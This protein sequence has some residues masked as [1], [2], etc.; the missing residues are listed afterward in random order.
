M[1]S[2][3]TRRSLALLLLLLA[4]STVIDGLDASIVN[5]A[6]PTISSDLHV[7]VADTSSITVSYILVLA[8]LLL[9]FAKLAGNGLVKRMFIVGTVVFTV[10]SAMCGLSM[11]FDELVV[12]RFIQG[13]GAGLMTAAVP[14]MIVN[15]LPHDKKG[16]GMGVLAVA[17][18]VAIVIGPSVG[19]VITSLASWHW[20]FLVNIPFGIL[21]VLLA[22]WLL[23]KDSGYSRS[24]NP[25]VVNS[26]VTA[27]MV[28]AGIVVIQ[29]I[30]DADV[31]MIQQVVLSI[32]AVLSAVIL[33]FR[34]H[35]RPETSPVAVEMLKRRDFQLL[36]FAF[37]MTC[38]IIMGVQ[39]VL[40]YHFQI[41]GGFSVAESGLLLSVA[42]LF[43]IILSI[44]VGRWC[45]RRKVPSVLAGVG[46]LTFC[47]IF[48]IVSP[49]DEVHL[50]IVGLAIMGCSMAFAGT[51]LA[52]ALIHHADK[53]HQ[54]DA[55]T[56]LLEVNYI[57]ASLGVVVFALIFEAGMGAGG[58]GTITAAEL[59]VCFERAMIAGCVMSVIA[60]ICTVVVKNI[61][62]EQSGDSS[63]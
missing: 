58:I 57:A 45:D 46:R 34:V 49:K 25:D 1:D 47:V 8:A 28:G 50:L 44:P 29:D 62:P 43:A 15:F 21:T 3:E 2:F 56:F 32:L 5:V 14:V 18:G 37:T 38:M 59:Q 19:G 6:L 23:P 33:V 24:K 36:A 16:V 41:T 7:S 35:S 22:L 20:I 60:I 39:Y 54:G 10:A 13:A 27:V 26:V 55:A 52:T 31:S 11:D 48:M 4:L 9:P 53:E 40:P 61:V 63:Q 12:F 30:T 17:S 51:G 42:S